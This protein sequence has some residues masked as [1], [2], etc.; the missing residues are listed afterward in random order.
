[1]AEYKKGRVVKGTV[2]GIEP[3]GAF[4]SFGEFYSG[5]I[6]ISEISHGFVKDIHDFLNIG[7]VIYTEI[8]EVDEEDYQL[9][10]SIKNIAYKNSRKYAGTHR[11]IIETTSGFHTLQKKLPQWIEENLKKQK[12]KINSVDK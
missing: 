3:Y 4:V 8:L 2:T 11:K 12:N 7:D 10:L 5:L 9:K 1:M 6:H